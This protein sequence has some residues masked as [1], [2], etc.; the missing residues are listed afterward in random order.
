MALDYKNLNSYGLEA[1]AELLN[2]CFA[3]YL[4]K[5]TFS[6][7]GL[8]QMAISD[9]LDTSAS[10]V[11]LHD[12]VPSGVAL[13]AK[14]GTT[15]RLAGMAILPAER[16]KGTGQALVDRLLLDARNRG[17]RE[18]VLEVIENNG[19]AVRLY[20]RAGF[21]KIRRLVGFEA[22]GVSNSPGEP[23]IEEV[24]LEAAGDAVIRHGL[25]DLP[26]QIS[27]ET[28]RHLKPPCRA[29]RHHGAWVIVSNLEAPLLVL[30]GFV[31]QAEPGRQGDLSKLIGGLMVRHPGKP[32]RAPALFP[33]EF[34]S[35]LEQ[36]GFVKSATTQW[37]MAI[38][39]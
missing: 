15:S 8:G 26:W 5:I 18:M 23:L 14:R 21:G 11:V 6:A 2:R 32:W 7:A 33:E 4:V 16:K 10:Q 9:S 37:Q 38:E 39:L 12:G 19:V 27:G 29:F 36:A 28:L 30:R 17:D 34:S 31:V 3:D 35:L 24:T 22:S 20:E 13:M 25:P 1:A